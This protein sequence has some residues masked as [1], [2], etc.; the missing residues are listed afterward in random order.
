MK[1]VFSDVDGTFQD[2]GETVPEINI[3]AVKEMQ[4][5]GHH[6]VFVT[7]RGYDLVQNMQTELGI[8]CDVIFGNGAGLKEMGK[9]PQYTN[10]L[11]L[12]TCR[13]IVEIL[14]EENI[15]YFFHTDQ[16]V[17][18]KPMKYYQQH[19]Q[20]LRE[21]L[22]PMGEQGERLMDFKEDYFENNCLHHEEPL[23]F[24]AEHPERHIVKIELMLPDDAEHPRLIAALSSEETYVFNSFYKTLEIVNPKSTKGTAIVEYLKSFDVEKTYGIGDGGND[25]PMLEVVDVAVAVAN[26]SDEVKAQADLIVDSCLD[27]GVGQFIYQ[28]ILM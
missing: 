1:V 14:E 23:N 18:V 17:I 16:E 4:A 3:K 11:D 28:Y 6:F 26:A 2:L 21:S 8:D 13:K 27:G 25:L 19:M 24:L 15:F 5:A 12:A 22:L 9:A 7:G 10:C 20:A